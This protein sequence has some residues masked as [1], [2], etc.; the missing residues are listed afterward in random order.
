MAYERDPS[1]LN[2][3]EDLRRRQALDNEL[4]ADPELAEGPA[5]GGR[6]ALFAIAVIAILGVVFYG[7]NNSSTGPSTAQNPPATTS[8]TA[9]NGSGNTMSP[10]PVSPANP[11][12]NPGQTTGSAPAPQPGT[13]SSGSNNPADAGVNSNPAPAQTGSDSK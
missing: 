3:T 5:S 12:A 8:S 4:Q 13:P 9:Q 11:N 2:R 7:L 1:D 6:M 10:N